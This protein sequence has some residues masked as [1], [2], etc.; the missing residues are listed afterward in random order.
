MPKLRKKASDQSVGNSP[1]AVVG[2][3][4]PPTTRA[5]QAPEERFA[6]NMERFEQEIQQ[7]NRPELRNPWETN[8]DPSSDNASTQSGPAAGVSSH[9]PVVSQD[10]FAERIAKRRAQL[11][12]FVEQQQKQQDKRAEKK[13]VKAAKSA[14]RQSSRPVLVDDEVMAKNNQ[15][16]SWASRT[17][18]HFQHDELK[19][20]T[21]PAFPPPTRDPTLLAQHIKDFNDGKYEPKGTQGM[22]R[23]AKRRAMTDEIA[24]MLKQ[25]R[26]SS[27][28][29]LE[30]DVAKYGGWLEYGPRG[31]VMRFT[32]EGHRIGGF[33]TEK[34]EEL[35]A[36]RGK[37]FPQRQCEVKLS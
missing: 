2:P 22:D 5:S 18:N 26:K 31:G 4:A 28:E 11:E 21:V 24:A 29:Q 37:S 30:K 33:M 23:K 6:A 16:A 32:E 7:S 14:E 8:R 15:I 25:S 19:E 36:E 1:N 17:A 13:A 9:T 27:K 3:S 10:R 12:Q 34:Q 20:P 35:K